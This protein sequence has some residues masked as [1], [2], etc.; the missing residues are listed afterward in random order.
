MSNSVTVLLSPWLQSPS[1]LTDYSSDPWNEPAS[2]PPVPSLIPVS[3]PIWRDPL[4]DHGEMASLLR[5]FQQCPSHGQSLVAQMVKNLPAMWDTWV[6]SWGWEESLQKRPATHCSILAWPMDRGAWQAIVHGVTNNQTR[7]SDW[8][9]TSQGGLSDPAGY[10]LHY[11]C[12]SRGL[13]LLPLTTWPYSQDLHPQR[14]NAWWSEVCVG[15][16]MC[17]TLS[18][19]H[20]L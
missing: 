19:P 7:L 18:W 16:Q 17:P 15:A 20:R 12:N 4:L 3:V 5:V 2:F 10:I 1:A 11:L 14:S 13:S 8:A 6:R 9:H